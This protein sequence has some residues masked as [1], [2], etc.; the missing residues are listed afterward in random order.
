MGTSAAEPGPGRDE[1]MVA[2]VCAGKASMAEMGR[3]HGITRE[4]VRQIVAAAGGASPRSPGRLAERWRGRDAEVEAALEANAWCM[5]WAARSLGIGT[6]SFQRLV[7]AG[8]WPGLAERIDE[9]AARKARTWWEMRQ[10][11][12]TWE[13]IAQAAGRSTSAVY[14]GVV[15]YAASHKL[16]VRKGRV[17]PRRR[18]SGRRAAGRME[19]WA[20]G[21]AGNDAR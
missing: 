18:G 19:K 10:A 2:E 3:R 17:R 5:A 14:K 7:R 15:R 8:L 11:R 9:E 13:E 20:R 16:R 12:H 21:E 4:R 1:A 6:S